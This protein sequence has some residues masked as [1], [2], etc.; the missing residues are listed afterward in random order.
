MLHTWCGSEPC[1]RGCGE[2]GRQGLPE[3]VSGRR[4]GG[5][6]PLPSPRAVE[7]G[8]GS[9]AGLRRA[10]LMRDASRTPLRNRAQGH[11]AF[12]PSASH[13][14]RLCLARGS[15]TKILRLRRAIICIYNP[16]TGPCLHES[17][18][19]I[20][21]HACITADRTAHTE[22]RTGS[23]VT[24]VLTCDKSVPR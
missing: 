6:E 4:D 21:D 9:E 20:C 19:P 1:G 11:S 22:V 23:L 17:H 16:Y 18:A 10:R 12:A 3:G 5:A 24:A 2:W 8:A 15:A 7:A 14:A 13:R